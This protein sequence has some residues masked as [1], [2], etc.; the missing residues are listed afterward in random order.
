MFQPYFEDMEKGGLF[1]AVS[2]DWSRTVDEQKISV[3]Q[4]SAARISVIGAM[5]THD[6][7]A[8]IDA[9]KAVDEVIARF[10]DKKNG[11]YFYA[12]DK[13]WNITCREKN[14]DKTSEIFGVLMHLYEVSY[15]DEY[16]LKALNFL[17][18]ALDRACDK[19]NGGFFSLYTE[20]WDVA[21]DLK[22]L[23]TQCSM[24]QHLNG[25]W[26]DGMDSPFGAKASYHK[27]RAKELGDLILDKAA[28]KIH[29]GFYTS[30]TRDWRPASK[31]KNIG[32]MASLALT[33][34]FHYHNLG[35]SIWGPRRG[36]HA[37]TGR[38]YPAVY[39][40]RGPAPSVE[41]VSEHAYQFGKKV[42]EIG[43]ILVNQAWDN[44]QGGFYSSLSEDLRPHDTTKQISTHINCLLALN[45]AYRLT[46]ASRFQKRC[47]EAIKTIEDK[48]FDPDNAGVYVSF[49]RDWT[50]TV[51]D[52]ICGPNLIVGGIM[53]MI[54]PVAQG[55]D[56]T[57]NTH[58]LWIDPF[59]QKIKAGES[60]Q[61]T[62]TVQNQGFEREKIRIGGL[63]APS[64][65]INPNDV[66]LD[67]APHE[68]KTFPLAITPP[69]D[70]PPGDYPFEITCMGAGE[71]ADY[72]SRSGK[73]S[74]R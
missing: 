47:A 44:E 42:V 41:P 36:S 17:D 39:S 16:L 12:A 40:F 21:T 14:L 45:V 48:C 49:T 26:K 74:I 20:N 37:F 67:L 60:A 32:E 23:T 31:D 1:H 71:V 19:Q 57:R 58:A 38:P 27:Q 59:C 22:D 18:V 53:S 64:R 29:G 65:W 51:R 8:I 25:S 50:P 55:L 62:V 56:V 3:D 61:F 4:F 68:T 13:D 28:D 46:G 66:T 54:G 35:P 2:E 7:D 6:H 30:F 33:L 15:K 10:E 43:D 52:K 34:Y 5:I 73:I 24:L 9:G 63:S 72:V 69:K 11:G 70:M